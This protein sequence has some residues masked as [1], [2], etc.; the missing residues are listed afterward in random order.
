[1]CTSVILRSEVRAV[2]RGAGAPSGDA[3]VRGPRPGD[4]HESLRHA[5]DARDLDPAHECGLCTREDRLVVLCLDGVGVA[6]EGS[7][8]RVRLELREGV[9]EFEEVLEHAPACLDCED[10]SLLVLSAAKRFV[11]YPPLVGFG[12]LE[13]RT[14][15]LV[16]AVL[17]RRDASGYPDDG[18]VGDVAVHA[19]RVVRAL[20]HVEEDDVRVRRGL[21]TVGVRVGTQAAVGVGVSDAAVCRADGVQLF[22]RPLLS[23]LFD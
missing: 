6:V 13:H 12:A 10:R 23:D 22:H 2:A 21:R 11:V 3:S 15:L 19:R 20:G 18:P 9:E 4:E 5:L 14:C 1:M 8:V 16:R 7:G 17:G